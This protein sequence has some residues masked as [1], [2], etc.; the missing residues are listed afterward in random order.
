MAFLNVKNRAYS[1][2]AS[3]ISDT[4]TSLTV[5]SGE[6]ARFPTENFHI[7]IDNEILLCTSR[8]GDTFTV[9]RAQEDTTPAAHSA[10]ARVELR[11]TAKIIQDLVDG[12]SEVGVSSG[13]IAALTEKTS[14][15]NADLLVIEDSAA[16]NAPKKVQV[17]NLPGGTTGSSIFVSCNEV[18]WGIPTA[19]VYLRIYDLWYTDTEARVL[20]LM[21]AAGTIDK[22]YLHCDGNTTDGTL[23]ITL[24]KNGADTS[25]V[26]SLPAGTTTANSGANSF[27]VAAGDRISIKRSHTGIT[28]GNITR[29]RIAFRFTSS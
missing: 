25:V 12:K 20:I 29:I 10:G 13:K 2:L 16:S 9:T 19:T 15:V 8:S 26:A 21:P 14:P 27:T 18:S 3:D 23:H 22:L 24:R 6:G 17:G 4:A 28:T 7:T 11:I 1:T 5:A